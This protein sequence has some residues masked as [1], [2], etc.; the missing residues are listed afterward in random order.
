MGARSPKVGT[1]MLAFGRVIVQKT[2][3]ILAVILATFD[4]A[5]CENVMRETETISETFHHV[6]R[7]TIRVSSAWNPSS[8]ARGVKE[9]REGTYA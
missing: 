6:D 7:K 3:D 5:V 1:K 4:S 8:M 9:E 2:K